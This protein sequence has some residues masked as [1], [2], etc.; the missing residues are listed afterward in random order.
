MERDPSRTELDEST[1]QDL[2]RM[3]DG[4]LEG[5]PRAELEVRIAG[6]PRLRAALERQRAGSAPLR[7]LDL[8]A[9]SSLRARLA[10]QSRASSRPRRRRQFAFAGA[11]AGAAAAAVLAAV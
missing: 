6:S 3:A 4:S 10:L 11:L 7:N 5:Y 1:R 8:Q 9:P 2:V